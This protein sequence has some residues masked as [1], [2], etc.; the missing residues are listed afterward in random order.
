MEDGLRCLLKESTQIQQVIYVT[1]PAFRKENEKRTRRETTLLHPVA[2]VHRAVADPAAQ[3]HAEDHLEDLGRTERKC[4]ITNCKTKNGTGK[5]KIL[6]Y[7]SV[8]LLY[9]NALLCV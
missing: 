9:I 4:W 7:S 2:L 1:F 3:H 5:G 8:G 6:S